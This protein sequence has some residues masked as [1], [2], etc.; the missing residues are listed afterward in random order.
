MSVRFRFVLV[1]LAMSVGNAAA[2]G[3]GRAQLDRFMNGVNALEA[4]FQQTVYSESGAIKQEVSGRFYMQRPGRFRWDYTKP[5][6]QVI[7]AD[8]DRLWI[9]DKDLD[10][11]TVRLQKEAIGDTPALLLGGKADLT[12]NFTISEPAAMNP[13]QNVAPQGL[14]WVL[15]TPHREESGFLAL[16]IGF[17]DKHI[18]VMELDDN[19]GQKTVLV[20]SE[21]RE[22]TALKPALFRFKPPQGVDLVDNTGG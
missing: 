18:A 3:E 12:R 9:Y 17:R 5:Y 10:Q 4:S 15:L 14:H 8:G 16:R 7:V 11:V 19:F 6:E 13:E 22:N 1:L 21:V 2:A 20:F